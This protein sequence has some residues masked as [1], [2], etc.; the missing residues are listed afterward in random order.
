MRRIL[1]WKLKNIQYYETNPSS[2]TMNTIKILL[3]KVV[4]QKSWKYK[5]G[6][7]C[8]LVLL[9]E[10]LFTH[11]SDYLLFSFVMQHFCIRCGLKKK[12]KKIACHWNLATLHLHWEPLNSSV[13]YNGSSS[14]LATCCML[15]LETVLLCAK[16][17][18]I[19]SSSFRQ[20]IQHAAGDES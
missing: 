3:S 20:R 15:A 9:S 1:L 7:M 12:K 19:H 8:I 16:I 10:L 14:F 5:I 4:S 11:C 2:S 6:S 18:R 17:P 13:D